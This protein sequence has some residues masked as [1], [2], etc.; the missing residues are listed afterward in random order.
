MGNKKLKHLNYGS[1]KVEFIKPGINIDFVGKRKIA[2]IFSIVVILFGIISI[3]IKGGLLYGIDF[4]GGTLIQIKFNNPITTSEI[5][6]ILRETEIGKS[7]IQQF[8]EAKN[9]EFIIRTKLGDENMGLLSQKVK[10]SL[11]KRI[12]NEQFEIRRVEMV[13]PKVGKDLRK[14][15]VNS[16]IYALL[17]I[18]IYI[19]LRFEFKFA[20]GAVGA[21]IHDVLITVG[22][23]SIA[24]KE[25]NLTTLAALLAI[26]GYS[27]NDTII[28][29]DRIREN[30]GKRKREKLP[31]IINISI[32]E[33]LNRTIITSTTTLFVVLSIFFIAGGVIH[34]FAFALVIGIIVGTYS[35]I[36][37]ASPLV[38]V[39]EDL[40]AKKRFKK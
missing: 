26:V 7:T 36:Y 13:G 33:V 17:G 2:M 21:L 1:I 16:I 39:L 28:V 8:G 29:Y 10:T 3:I 5:K 18:L 20:V 31:K 32:N 35:S 40:F 23:F 25:F 15:G 11:S 38:I 30:L 37:V 27:L 34:D 9:Y 12:E 19:T 24:N 4:S 14:K 6:E 22:I